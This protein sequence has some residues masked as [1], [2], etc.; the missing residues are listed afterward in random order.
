MP[1]VMVVVMEC[2]TCIGAKSKGVD[3]L[4]VIYTT[5]FSRRGL[6]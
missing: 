1:D 6:S 3:R 2:I 4:L 5:L